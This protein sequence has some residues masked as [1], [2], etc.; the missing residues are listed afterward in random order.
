MTYYLL[1]LVGGR[2][3]SNAK[4]NQELGITV[5]Q[6]ALEQTGHAPK[7]EFATVAEFEA[8][9]Q[10]HE[11]LLVDETEQR[12]Q[13]PGNKEMQKDYYSGKKIYVVKEIEV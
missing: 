11:T 12:K 5:L 10:E 7:R 3:G 13:P 1:G 8:Y 2:D 4:R 6:E 9:F